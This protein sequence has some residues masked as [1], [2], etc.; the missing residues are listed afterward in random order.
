MQTNAPNA[1]NNNYQL[2]REV[3]TSP[4][5][6]LLPLC[7]HTSY[8]SPRWIYI[9]G[10]DFVVFVYIDEAWAEF[11]CTVTDNHYIWGRLWLVTTKIIQESI[12]LVIMFL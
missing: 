10:Y 2:T 9:P 12:E 11:V 4:P 7:Q 8:G 6:H 3:G 1:T 5:P